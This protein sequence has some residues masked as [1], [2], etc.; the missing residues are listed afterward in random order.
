M[1]LSTDNI[2]D[3]DTDDI[4]DV[5]E[6][7]QTIKQGRG[8]KECIHIYRAK[9]SVV[10]R[11]GSGF[12]INDKGVFLSAGHN[13]KDTSFKYFGVHDSQQYEIEELFSEYIEPEEY[14]SDDTICKDLFVGKLIHFTPPSNFVTGILSRKKIMSLI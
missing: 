10:E 12:I 11:I 6:I 9:N 2:S 3:N 7:P 8:V 13:F 5:V 14:N 4:D 1:K